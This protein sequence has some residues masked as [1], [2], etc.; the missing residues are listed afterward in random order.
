[1]RYHIFC[2]LVASTFCVAYCAEAKEIKKMAH[3]YTVVK[4]DTLWD[5]SDK[6]LKNPK[7]WQ[8][9]W[10]EN[11]H[12]NNPN[13]IYPGD[14]LNIPGRKSFNTSYNKLTDGDVRSKKAGR[15][16][17][18]K[19]SK[20]NDGGLGILAERRV[21]KDFGNK[22][23]ISIT[24]GTSAKT[25]KNRMLVSCGFIAKNDNMPSAIIK[26]L[27]MEGELIYE[28]RI[29]Y[30]ANNTLD[31]VPGNKYTVFRYNR[32]VHHPDTNKFM[33]TLVMILGEA[34]VLKKHG[35]LMEIVITASYRT[36]KAEDRL[37]PLIKLDAPAKISRGKKVSGTIVDGYG[38]KQTFAEG[39]FVYIDL[40]NADGVQAGEMYSIYRNIGD[41]DNIYSDELTQNISIE[42]GKFIS[43][44]SSKTTTSGFIYSSK[45]P[46]E[47]GFRI[48]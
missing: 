31:L 9:I 23:N 24:T 30:A 29:A 2:L 5:I 26:A 6:Y 46:V 13:L 39:D 12:I 11:K 3:N 45:L 25:I 21:R 22:V 20:S 36:I 14:G 1:M 47:V 42:V 28:S 33:G 41:D 15:I 16:S 43:I 34:K 19:A 37:M 18:K 27:K 17:G 8:D 35:S 48:K 10:K 32:K 7:D 4:G 40:G 44:F 38:D